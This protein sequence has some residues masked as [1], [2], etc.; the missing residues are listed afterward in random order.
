MPFDRAELERWYAGELLSLQRIAGRAAERLGRPVSRAKVR[1][2]LL[3]LG[4]PRRSFA[5][6]ARLRAQRR[7]AGMEGTGD[8]HGLAQA[9][10]LRL[11][12]IREETD[13][14]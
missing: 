6:A 2:W 13:A 12:D 14:L 1:E 5:A 4:I 9:G 11:F 8:A 3:A 10:Q 7:R